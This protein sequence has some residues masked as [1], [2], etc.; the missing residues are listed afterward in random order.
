MTINPSDL[1]PSPWGFEYEECAVGRA[2]IGCEIKAHHLNPSGTIHG[3]VL[4]T[5]MDEAGAMAGMRSFDTDE[6]RGS[7]TVSLTGQFTAQAQSGRV[8]AIGTVVRSGQRIYFSRTEITDAAGEVLAF[9]SSTH[10][11]QGK[12]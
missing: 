4:L 11:Y 10:R 1:P 7:M 3:G 9:G 12:I 2:R 8:T 6:V 5:L